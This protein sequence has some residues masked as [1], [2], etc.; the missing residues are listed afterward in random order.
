MIFVESKTRKMKFKTTFVT[1]VSL[2][3]FNTLFGQDYQI[4]VSIDSTQILIGDYLRA[5]VNITV[6]KQ[7]P[8]L[9]SKLLPEE[10]A[11]I[12]IINISK[13]D[14]LVSENQ[15]SL[16][17]TIT[18]TCF[19]S[20]SYYFPSLSIFTLDSILLA[21]S[22]SLYFSVSPVPVDTTAAIK[23]IK[24]PV[25]VRITFKE[26]LPYILIAVGCVIIILLAIWLILKYAKKKVKV[27]LK[28]RVKPKE[29]AHIIALRNL[30]ALRHKKLWQAGLVKEY[31][32]ELTDII[33]IY[34]KDRWDIDAMEMTSNE[35]FEAVRQV[36]LDSEQENQLSFILTTAD[37]VKFAKS[38]PLPDDHDKCFNET[39]SF[40][41]KTATVTTN[42]SN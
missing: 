8:F 36:K 5:E 32:S 9:F 26:L 24:L 42:S 21:Q 17:Q 11:P 13:F 29:P 15:Y 40:I 38:K 25:K 20:G 37:L 7:S 34:L 23:D 33:R 4:K 35:I 14:T 27:E 10:I 19:D 28:V 30:D 39:K 22:D 18:V 2:I 6:P 12:E 31:Y 3:L 41:E 16:H 1:F